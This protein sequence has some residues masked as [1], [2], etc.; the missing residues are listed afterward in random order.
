M[1]Y[2]TSSVV[3]FT[4]TC[5]H[6]VLCYTSSPLPV[7]TACCVVISAIISLH[8]MLCN[9]RCTRPDMFHISKITS[10]YAM[11]CRVLYVSLP[12]PVYCPHA[13]VYISINIIT[14]VHFMF[15]STSLR[16]QCT[17]HVLLY[18]AAV[19]STLSSWYDLCS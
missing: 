11:L 6:S 19:I 4:I 10:M 7:C 3:F 18:I 13:V 15:W 5:I 14:S 8:F 1:V 9:H 2:N 17:L 12:S 16:H